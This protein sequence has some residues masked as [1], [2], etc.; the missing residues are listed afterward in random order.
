MSAFR[1]KYTEEW[2]LLGLIEVR[3]EIGDWGIDRSGLDDYNR[4]SGY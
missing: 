3:L 1:A 4:L 2:G